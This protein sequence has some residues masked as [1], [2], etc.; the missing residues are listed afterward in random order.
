MKIKATKIK[1][2]KL[3][4]GDLF[5]TADKLYWDNHHNNLSIAEKVYI[6]TNEPC[7]KDQENEEIYKIEIEN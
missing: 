3:K 7:P 5:S 2:K 1:A 4:A 6:R